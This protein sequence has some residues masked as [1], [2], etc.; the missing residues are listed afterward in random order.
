LNAKRNTASAGTVN[1]E[2]TTALLQQMA[3]CLY[4]IGCLTLPLLIVRFA[5]LTLSDILFAVTLMIVT[6]IVI[7]H[8]SLRKVFGIKAISLAALAY[9]ISAMVSSLQLGAEDLLGSLAATLKLFYLTIV[10]FSLGAILALRFENGVSAVRWWIWGCAISGAGAVAQVLISPTII[11]GTESIFA[12]AVGFTGHP[13]D[14]GASLA[15]ALSPALALMTNRG[16]GHLGRWLRL[17]PVLL[18]VAGLI[19]SA[20]ASAIICAAVSIFAWIWLTKRA[21]LGAGMA[22]AIF[23]V[24]AILGAFLDSEKVDLSAVSDIY[25]LAEGGKAG[26]LNERFETFVSAWTF[27]GESPLVGVGT[28]AGG[29][30]T[31]NGFATHNIFLGAWYETGLLGFLSIVAILCFTGLITQRVLALCESF[32]ERNVISALAGSQIAF[33]VYSL[34]A[35]GLY[36]RYGWISVALMIVFLNVKARTRSQDNLRSVYPGSAKLRPE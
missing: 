23:S 31:E 5:S 6:I 10:W 36:Q 8:R 33:L 13:N 17:I 34:T 9:T 15:I 22:I 30:P 14:L 11:P 32:Y 16:E 35:P 21:A 27:I 2:M 28:K 26:T 29:W 3:W 18:I 25:Q 19:L 20:S 7:A 1:P 24:T 12:R 4:L